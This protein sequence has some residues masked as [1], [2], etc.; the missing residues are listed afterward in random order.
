MKPYSVSFGGIPDK[1]ATWKSSSFVVIPFPIDLTTTYV[2]GTRNGPGAIIEASGHME[3]FDEE[4]KIEPYRAGI[5]VSTEIPMLTTGPIAMLKELEKRMKAVMRAGKFPI[6]LGG[7]HSGTCGAV[8]ALKKKYEDLTILQFDAHAD[9]RDTYLGTQWNHAC[10]GR[11]I[12]DSGAKLVQVGVRS[13]SEE[14]DRF[15]R[16]SETVK[17]FYASEVRDNL[18][19]VTRGIVSGLSGNVYISIDLDVFDPGIMPAVGTP[20]PGGLDWFEVV[21]ILRDVMRSDCNIVGFDIME[22]SP[23]PGI[24]APD[25]LAA[26][27]CYRMMGWVLAKREEK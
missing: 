18:A 5:F 14:E 11:R 20:E 12:V 21:D 27:L 23:L 3:L 2:T 13:I 24:V 6:L 17:T 10:V 9:L 15:L 19:D 1:Y 26:K 4:N 7:E 16:K 25:F 8:S 22:L